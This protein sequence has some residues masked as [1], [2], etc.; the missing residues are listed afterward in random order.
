MTRRALVALAFVA[1]TPAATAPI[2]VKEEP[3]SP[4]PSVTAS[5]SATAR[6][7]VSL[8]GGLL[9]PDTMKPEP[10]DPGEPTGPSPPCVKDEDCWSRTCC[11]ATKPEQ[12]VHGTLAKG[13]ALKE[14]ACKKTAAPTFTCACVAGACKGRPPKEP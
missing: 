13:C 9:V 10:E 8:T 2:K 1:C 12:C 14:V 7:K 5:V 4:P 6:P 3:V 11:P